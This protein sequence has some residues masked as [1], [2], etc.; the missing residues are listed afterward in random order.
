MHLIVYHSARAS[1]FKPRSHIIIVII[2]FIIRPAHPAG[3]G[4]LFIEA[5]TSF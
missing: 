2:F 5:G 4:G 3:A 1:P